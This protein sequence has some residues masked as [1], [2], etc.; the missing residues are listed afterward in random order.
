MKEKV[1]DLQENFK[2]NTVMVNI[3]KLNFEAKTKKLKDYKLNPTPAF[4]K[5]FLQMAG[6][7]IF[8]VLCTM[9]F[10]AISQHC[11]CIN[12]HR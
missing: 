10:A 4:V 2:I 11:C 7:Y 12:S 8:P 5:C 3:L 9:L 1:E 6:Q